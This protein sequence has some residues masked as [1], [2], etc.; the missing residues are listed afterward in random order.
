MQMELFDFSSY[1]P[2]RLDELFAAYY[3]CRKNKRKTF[4]ALD[5]E[6]DFEARLVELWREINNGTY[7]PGRSISFIVDK[8]VKREIFA[9]D[10]RD[11]VVHHLVI[12]KLLPLFETLFIKD[13]YSCREGK[14]A[15]YGVNRV[16]EFVRECSENYTKDC[17]ILKMD[18]QSFF[19]TID[20][21]IL[22]KRLQSFIREY[23][24]GV[25]KDIIL[26]LVEIIVYHC[27]QN[28]CLIKG[29][30]S[31]WNGL[32]HSKSLFYA[33]KYKGLPIGN[34]SSQVFANFYMDSFD[35]FVKNNLNIKYYGRYVDDFVIVH[36]SKEFLCEAKN[37]LC[38]FMK[39]DL[40]LTLHPRKIYLQHFSKGVKFIGSV[41]KPGRNYIG[42]R[43]KG[44]FFQKIQEYNHMAE[45]NPNYA[46][47]AEKFQS[48]INSYLGFMVH[49]SSYKIRY[50]MLWK[51][52]DPKWWKLMYTY[53]AVNKINLKQEYTVNVKALK[54]VKRKAR[55]V[56]MVDAE[57]MNRCEALF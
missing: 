54:E 43:T 10:F 17:Y 41:I 19:M 15:L 35:K 4:N 32:P 28:N 16:A 37:K 42:N 45:N 21:R 53:G 31:D 1:N 52:V 13:S 44:N 27:P 29:K 2:V 40:H 47:F 56:S 38:E 22:A 46:N 12:N 55:N 18:I 8:P 51:Y 48:S 11:R 49:Y 23:Y 25:D 7:Y 34:L 24:H 5:F 30:K 26:K 20:K 50:N 6:G 9:A 57:V 14:G 36:E 33:G 3:D 39:E